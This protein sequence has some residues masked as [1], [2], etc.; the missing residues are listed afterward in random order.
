MKVIPGD[1]AVVE[2]EIFEETALVRAVVN[3]QHENGKVNVR[4]SDYGIDCDVS[5]GDIYSSFKMEGEA[6]NFC[7]EAFVTCAPLVP[8]DF[9]TFSSEFAATGILGSKV[10]FHIHDVADQM[11]GIGQPVPNSADTNVKYC[12]FIAKY[13]PELSNQSNVSA[14]NRSVNSTFA[15]SVTSSSQKAVDQRESSSFTLERDQ[16]YRVLITA[17]KNRSPHQAEQVLHVV[18][19]EEWEDLNSIVDEAM[20]QCSEPMENVTFGTECIV[21]DKPYDGQKNDAGY[22]RAFILD[23]SKVA[24]LKG[25]AA[26][27][28]RV[29]VELLDTGMTPCQVIAKIHEK[30]KAKNLGSL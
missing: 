6:V 24:S 29:Y 4:L 23:P 17:V 25:K 20:K 30:F 27:K 5:P 16:K 12:G 19:W 11:I 9:D 14:S 22:R 21:R 3:T 18:Q 2:V 13:F 28:E 7:F 1:Q 15:N 10:T 8:F 26:S